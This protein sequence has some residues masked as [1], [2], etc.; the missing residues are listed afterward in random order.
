[1]ALQPIVRPVTPQDLEAL[2]DMVRHL[3]RFHGDTPTVT[4]ATL[5]RDCLGQAPWLHVLVAE[6]N[7]ALC[8][9][10]MLSPRARAQFGERAMD[11]HHLYVQK[12][13]RGRGVGGALVRA[14]EALADTLG[15]RSLSVSS[16]PENDMAGRAYLA[17]GFRE[18][19]SGMRRFQRD[20]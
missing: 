19:R 10:A 13:L 4:P 14:A 3:A 18:S 15:A 1:M 7:G 5:A 9:Y 12:D 2:A 16:M 20:F 17:M 8:A 6:V 11:L